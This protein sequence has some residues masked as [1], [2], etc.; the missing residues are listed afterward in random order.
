VKKIQYSPTR[1]VL[2]GT[3]LPG[4]SSAWA[5]D[6]AASS[7]MTGRARRDLIMADSF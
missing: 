2:L 6:A 1:T 5:I 7:S 3:S 4:I